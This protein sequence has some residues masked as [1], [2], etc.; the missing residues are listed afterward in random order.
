MNR[1]ILILSLILG[2]VPHTTCAQPSA[3]TSAQNAVPLPPMPEDAEPSFDVATIKPSDTSAPHGRFIRIDGRHVLAFNMSVRDLIV[4]AYGLQDREIA[5]GPPSL[6]DRHFDVDGVPDVLGRPNRSQSRSMFQKLL[7]SRLKLRFHHEPRSL[8]AY[9]IQIANGGPKLALTTRK[10]GDGTNFSY[11]CPP[12]L[13]VLNYSMSDFAKG[14]QDV[15]LDKPVV[16]QTGLKNRY[17]FNLKWTP[18]DSQSYC[19]ANSAGPNQDPDSP[20]GM[21]TAIQEQLGLKLVPTKAT[22]QVMVIDHIEM[23]SEN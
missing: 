9:A 8:P 20:P 1:A 16:D 22:V 11:S 3:S 13:T 15:F 17:D 6:M 10:S 14:M 18:D 19:P 2:A 21:Y 23:P 7:V 4:Y 5:A 12:A